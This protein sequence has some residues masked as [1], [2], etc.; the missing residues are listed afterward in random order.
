[1]KK[2]DDEEPADVQMAHSRIKSD[3]KMP[4]MY[5]LNKIIVPNKT[6]TKRR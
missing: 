4:L 5:I 1:M 3:N 2:R 6:K